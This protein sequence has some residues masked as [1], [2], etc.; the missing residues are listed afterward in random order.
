MVRVRVAR[1]HVRLDMR[2]R[3]P[4]P[5]TKYVDPAVLFV[6]LV[7]VHMAAE[8][9]EAGALMLLPLLEHRRQGLPPRAARRGRRL[10]GFLHAN[11]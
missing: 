3:Q 5:V 10:A 2:A 6:A 8:D 1:R 4:P 7:I 11:S 9:D